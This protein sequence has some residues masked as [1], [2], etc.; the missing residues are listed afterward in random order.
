MSI[1]ANICRLEVSYADF[2]LLGF[3][4]FCKRAGQD[5]FDHIAASDPA[6]QRL[7]DASTR[8]LERDDH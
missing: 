4:Q 7:Y 8:W 5:I 6:F 1:L 2:N 3:L